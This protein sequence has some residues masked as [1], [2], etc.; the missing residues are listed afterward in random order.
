MENEAVLT[1]LNPRV[2][3]LLELLSR[4]EDPLKVDTLANALETSRRTIF[5]EL[6]Q[7][8]AILASFK[9]ELISI[10]GKGI[11]FSGSRESREKLLSILGENNRQPASKQERLF[12]LLLA[13]CANIGVIQKLYYYAKK[14]EV[15]ESTV[16]NDL[17]ELDQWL[18]GREVCITRK[19]GIGILCEGT[20]EA[21]RATLVSR[22]TT[23]GNT[24]GSS[25]TQAFGYPGVEIEEGV[26]KIL[27]ISEDRVDWMTAGS[28][29]MIAVYLMVAVERFRKGN[30]L[31]GGL[32]YSGEFQTN[33]AEHLSAELEK[34]FSII[35]PK[36]EK[37][38]L[39]EW[40]RSC[41]AKQNTP[42]KIG[43]AEQSNRIQSLVYQ[44]INRFDPP[45]AAILKT[46]EEFV[47]LLSVHL[48]PALARLNGRIS[49]P[50]PLEEELITNYPQVYQKTSR[51][52]KVLEEYI[53][54]P[55]PSN[56]I[57]FFEIHF[58]AAL[59]ALGEKNIRRRVL[60]AGIVC[61]AGIG[62][63]YMMASQVRKRF[64]GELEIEISG[65]ED[66]SIW[67][68]ADFLISTIA[69]ETTEKP[70]VLVQ[71]ML[72]EADYQKIREA[73][74][75][76]GFV[77]R[78]V[79]KP[80]K[81]YSLT[82]TLEK[83][84]EIF[85]QSKILF[86]G[87]SVEYIK[88]DCS[89]EELAFF[90]AERF[91]RESSPLLYRALMAREAVLTQ[92]VSELE[93]VLLHTRSADITAPVFGVIAPIGGVFTADYFKK[94]K[95]CVFML[96]PENAPQEMTEIMGGI[97]SALIDIPLFLKAVCDGNEGV[98]KTIFE[99]ELSEA[100]AQYCGKKLKM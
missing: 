67:N 52:V 91:S 68:D 75:A 74:N 31:T 51:A 13:L 69:L 30:I 4:A 28:C 16:S 38:A 100:L 18:S 71:T 81:S 90:A 10:S 23:G 44:M 95:S 83:L 35:L 29:G 65:S 84:G 40:I 42:L 17:D 32:K 8:G 66:H 98:I 43:T 62:T 50:N 64:K 88:A 24:G 20:E 78:G 34:E 7:V 25:Y 85:R 2:L 92:V 94:T 56:E 9:G 48:D 60:R 33:L 61:V 77:E 87:F 96:L 72:G 79:E 86:D 22:F 6:E 12:R 45:I 49:L 46:N 1:G 47:R 93:I 82:G 14:L 97:S 37:Q 73:I 11:A 21:I 70:C 41:R 5:R 89:F 36:A 19:S 57:T 53:G 76:Y 15:S 80:V 58:L 26:R 63:S 39:A 99:T 3:R 59:A 55:V 54:I 27:R